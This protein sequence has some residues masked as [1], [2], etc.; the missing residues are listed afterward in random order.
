MKRWRRSTWPLSNALRVREPVRS[1]IWRRG[2]SVVSKFVSLQ[3]LVQLAGFVIGIL[4][5]RSL[6]KDSYALY[7]ICV[8]VTAAGVALSEGGVTSVLMAEGGRSG[9]NHPR[10]ATVFAAAHR[11]RRVIGVVMVAPS[12]ALVLVLLT[13][14]GADVGLALVCTGI[15]I[16]TMLLSLD[17]GLYQVPMRLAG[18]YSRIQVTTLLASVLRLT[19]VVLLASVGLMS[20]WNSTGLILVATALEVWLLRR[21]ARLPAPTPLDESGA[22]DVRRQLRGTLRRVLPSSVVL[23]LQGQ[24]FLLALS[25]LSTPAVIAEV[26]ALARFTVVYVIFSAF[27]L[28]VVSSRFARSQVAA[29]RLSAYLAGS[30]ALYVLIVF[31]VV[32]AVWLASG[33]LLALLGDGYQELGT[34]LV[35]VTL[36][37]GLIALGGAWKNLNHARNWV[38][39]SWVLIPF[40]GIWFAAG[41]VLFDLT[42]V[43]NAAVWMALQSVP[44]LLSQAF[45]SILGLR[46]Q[47]EAASHA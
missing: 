40:T 38:R 26:S 39:G 27:F 9:H 33:L 43:R 3:L 22:D 42:D 47:S 1:R 35:I 18:R 2:F 15:V 14:N 28:D 25:F 5:V 34:E 45:C 24:A 6:D 23:V 8:S 11:F 16:A 44:L 36:G 41:L 37:S 20:V 30:L 31:A 17:R 32:V 19:L 4:I 13:R 46:G 10:F 7:A 29:R 21:A 12:A